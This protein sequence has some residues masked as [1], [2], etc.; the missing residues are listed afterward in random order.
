MILKMCSFYGKRHTVNDEPGGVRVSGGC[1]ASDAR[2][3][4]GVVGAKVGDGQRRA[5]RVHLG[6]DDPSGFGN[7]LCQLRVV[8]EPSEPAKTLKK[9]RKRV[10]FMPFPE[11]F[12]EREI[13][14]IESPEGLWVTI[15]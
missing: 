13:K 5:E 10:N 3:V 15:K 1:V 7:R 12:K 9:L 6:Y 14:L 8:F 2:V 4:A 11:I